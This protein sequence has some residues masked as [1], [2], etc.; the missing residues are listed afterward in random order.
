MAH[1][2]GQVVRHIGHLG[3]L[4]LMPNAEIGAAKNVLDERCLLGQPVLQVRPTVAL[5]V[6]PD[7]EMTSSHH[8]LTS[9]NKF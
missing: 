7:L 6:L 5:D 1:Q 9:V 8:H 2:I 4:G 3:E